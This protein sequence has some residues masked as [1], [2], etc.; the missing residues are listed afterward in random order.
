M[1]T[2]SYPNLAWWINSHG[3]VE[4]GNDEFS[5]SWV[6]VLDIGGMCWEDENSASLEEALMT[7]ER[8]ASREIATRFGEE[9]PKRYQ[10]E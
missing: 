2:E 8:W 7:A 6:R 1:F 3:W 5:Y 10:D 9:P 4:I